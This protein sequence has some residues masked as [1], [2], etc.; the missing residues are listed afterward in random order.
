MGNNK[1][2]YRIWHIISTYRTVLVLLW[3][4]R[5]F[6]ANELHVLVHLQSCRS[7]IPPPT[8]DLQNNLE[9]AANKYVSRYRKEKSKSK[10][11][12]ENPAVPRVPCYA[13]FRLDRKNYFYVSTF[14]HFYVSTEKVSSH[15]NIP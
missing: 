5:P 2:A 3:L 1:D 7:V 9:P 15:Y 10:E 14:L 4:T 12:W 8:A 6:C 11:N 13:S